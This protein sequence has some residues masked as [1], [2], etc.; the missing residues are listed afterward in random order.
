MLTKVVQSSLFYSS[1]YLPTTDVTGD[2]IK[3]SVTKQKI[4][5]QIYSFL[6]KQILFD[7]IQVLGGAT[8]IQ[9][10]PFT[11]EKV[12]WKVEIIPDVKTQQEGE[13]ELEHFT[14]LHF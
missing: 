11:E 10:F 3:I 8:Y 14:S 6:W 5:R 7:L 4:C 2:I 1:E 9:V 12:W 13:R